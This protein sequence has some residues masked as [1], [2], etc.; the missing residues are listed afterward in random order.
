MA[1][2]GYFLPFTP[3]GKAIEIIAI[4][5]KERLGLE[6]DASVDP[7]SVLEQVPGRLVDIRELKVAAPAAARQL[8]GAGR[9]EW[10]AI[11]F[12]ASTTTGVFDILVNPTHHKHR[13]RVSLM[14]EI[15]HLLRQHPMTVLS[16]GASVSDGRRSYNPAVEDEA[17]CVG[18]ACILPYPRLFHAVYRNGETIS[19]IA[20]VAEVSEDYVEYRIKRAGLSRVYSKQHPTGANRRPGLR[21]R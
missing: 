11:C 20:A 5:V 1:G 6:A 18:A 19:D 12:G 17:Y 8:L 21:I 15:V 4:E 14:E 7:Y 13:R 10:S 16:L 2:G 3:N 9:N